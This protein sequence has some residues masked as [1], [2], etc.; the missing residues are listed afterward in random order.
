M[1]PELI[2]VSGRKLA[3][4]D[5]LCDRLVAEAGYHKFHIV[6]PWLVNQFCPRHGISYDEYTANKPKWRAICQEEATAERAKDPD[7]LIR[8]FRDRLPELPRPLCVTA[9]RFAREVRLCLDL[10]GLALRVQTPDEVRRQRF[11][12]AGEDLALFDDPFEKEIDALP[13]HADVCG[14]LAPDQYVPIVRHLW[15]EVGG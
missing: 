6:Y 1:M 7:V 5:Y 9:V 14:S 2:F 12:D 10:G 15:A 3:G 11:L 13:V 8:V 4:K